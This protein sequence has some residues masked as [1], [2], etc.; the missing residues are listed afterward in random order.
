[1]ALTMT[2]IGV[3]GKT[4]LPVDQISPDTILAVDEALEWCGVNPGRLEVKFADQDAADAF[5]KEARSY[6]YVRE[7]GR[8]VVVGNTTQKGA[9]RFRVEPYTAPI[10]T[11]DPAAVT[12]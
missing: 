8:V 3:T 6:A 2:P 12:T 9:A 1:M 11:Q 5:L 4:R 7:A 10:S